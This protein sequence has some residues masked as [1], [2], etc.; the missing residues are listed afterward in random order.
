MMGLLHRID[1][2]VRKG[3]ILPRHSHPD[4]DHSMIV[5][6]GSAKVTGPNGSEIYNEGD[7]ALFRASREHEIEAMEDNTV[8]LNE[9]PG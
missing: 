7:A 1:D 6:R 5:M 9:M 2:Y 8:I 3:D 4:F